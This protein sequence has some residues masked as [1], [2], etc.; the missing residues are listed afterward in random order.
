MSLTQFQ[1]WLFI[2]VPHID[3]NTVVK[4]KRQLE[5]ESRNPVSSHSGNKETEGKKGSKCSN[6]RKT[7]TF[8][9]CV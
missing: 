3:S 2:C 6:G 9:L 5:S 1:G 8:V 7:K 4:I